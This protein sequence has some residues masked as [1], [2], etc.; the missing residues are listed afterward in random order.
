MDSSSYNNSASDPYPG[1]GAALQFTEQYSNE[2]LYLLLG[3]VFVFVLLMLSGII[4]GLEVAFFSINQN[5]KESISESNSKSEQTVF[6]LLQKPRSLLATILILNNLVNISIVLVADNI[7][8]TIFGKDSL[9]GVLVIAFTILV[10]FLIVFFGEI[11]PKVYANKNNVKFAKVFAIPFFYISGIVK[12]FSFTLMKLGKF[13]EK[14]QSEVSY[15]ISIDELSHA[16]E[17][18]NDKSTTEEQKDI[19]KNIVHLSTSNVKQV[20]RSRMDISAFDFDMDFHELMNQINKSGYSRVPIYKETIDKIE[21][22]LYIKDLLPFI[23]NDENFDWKSLIREVYFVPETKK[24][25]DLLRDFQE[26]HVHMAIVIDEYGGTSGLITMEDIIEEI[27]GEINDEFDVDDLF[28]SKLDENNIV[29]EGKTS[30]IDVCKILDIDPDYFD[31]VK[32]EN[33]SL[34]GLTFELMGKFPKINDKI[35]YKD[36]KFLIESVDKKRVKRVKI[37]RIAVLK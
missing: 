24:L 30:L 19:L 28:Y 34:G 26:K 37:S 18:T 7:T 6:A 17:I 31:E 16:I 35:E 9:N 25:D 21:G 12:P 5:Q 11:L 22:I 1:L 15:D 3:I 36:F 4:S 13:I 8:E 14:N 10:T 32:G 27:I 29:F 20:M 33:E 2:Y 23:E